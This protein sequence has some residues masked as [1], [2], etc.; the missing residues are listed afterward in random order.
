MDVEPAYKLDIRGI[1]DD[2]PRGCA[3]NG[4]R[5]WVGIR[6]DCCS[7]YTRVYRNHDGTAYE[8][9]CPKCLRSA[10]LRIGANGTDARFFIAE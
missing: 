3:S 8:G 6:F 5:P 9:R 10:N 4:K 1:E 7:V 2:S